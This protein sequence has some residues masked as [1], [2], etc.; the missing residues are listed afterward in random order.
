MT[1]PEQ[2]RDDFTKYIR[3]RVPM[4]RWGTIEEFEGIAAYLASDAS[5]FTTGAEIRIDG[6]FSVQG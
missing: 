5:T 6:G 3:H 2:Q 1:G 4:A